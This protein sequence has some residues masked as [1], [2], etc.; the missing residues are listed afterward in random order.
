MRK[1]FTLVMSQSCFFIYSQTGSFEGCPGGIS[2]NIFPT[3]SGTPLLVHGTD[4]Q[5]GASYRYNNAL[6]VPFNMY[7]IIHIDSLRNAA[8][9]KIDETDTGDISKDARFQPQVRPDI[10]SMTGNRRGF[11]QFTISFY[12]SDTNLPA[13]ITGLN[14]AHWDMDGHTTGSNGWFREMGWIVNSAGIKLSSMPFSDILNL[15]TAR[16]GSTAWEKFLGSTDEHAGVSGDPEVAMIAQYGPSSSVTFRM[17]YD[18]KYGGTTYS[19]PT[20][21]RYAAK[22]GCFNFI[23]AG[24]LPVNIN[25]FNAVAQDRST[26]LTWGTEREINHNHFEVEKSF[27]DKN[28]KTIAMVLGP[29]SVVGIKNYYEYLDKAPGKQPEKVSFYRLKQVDKD[30][31]VMY[32]AIKKVVND[33]AGFF[34]TQ[35]SPN[36]FT[37]RLDIKFSNG[38]QGIAEIIILSIAGETV[39]KYK[40]RINKGLNDL[41]VSGLEKLSRGIYIAKILVDGVCVDRQKLIKD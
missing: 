36:P 11:V 10:S 33:Q 31:K 5:R 29:R 2:S 7:A 40:S 34:I 38:Q 1:I 19:S 9:V 24:P 15:G 35:I 13:D 16:E 28:F 23:A 41:Q 37:G 39:A 20:F 30:G 32:S 6:K 18:F 12:N 26:H 3:F 27:S 17:G 22:F 21:R 25:Y 8:L 14:V 4:L